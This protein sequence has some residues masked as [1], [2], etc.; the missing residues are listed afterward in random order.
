MHF[1]IAVFLTRSCSNKC[2]RLVRRLLKRAFE[3]SEGSRPSVRDVKSPDMCGSPEDGTA[4][5]AA[6]A[7]RLRRFGGRAAVTMSGCSG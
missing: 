1:L 6:D 4:R 3:A 7:H 5:A 2:N